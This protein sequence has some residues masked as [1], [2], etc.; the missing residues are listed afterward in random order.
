MQTA[1]DKLPGSEQGHQQKWGKLGT[2]SESILHEVPGNACKQN[3]NVDNESRTNHNSM[4][5]TSARGFLCRVHLLT[6][7]CS[8]RLNHQIIFNCKEKL[9]V[10]NYQTIYTG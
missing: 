3:K 6:K 4:E 10:Y 1:P 2:G 8:L 7:T 9:A 5:N